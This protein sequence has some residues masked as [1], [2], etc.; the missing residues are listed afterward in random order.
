[1]IVVVS[2]MADLNG[3]KVARRSQVNG[4]RK[5]ERCHCTLPR[6]ALFIQTR[7]ELGYLFCATLYSVPRKTQQPKTPKE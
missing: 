1:M 2:D 6:K 7:A 3:G 5:G 4:I